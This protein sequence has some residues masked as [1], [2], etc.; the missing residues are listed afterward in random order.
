MYRKQKSLSHTS[1]PNSYWIIG[2]QQ[3]SEWESTAKR[4]I[5]SQAAAVRVRWLPP[6]P[7]NSPDLHQ[8]QEWSLARVGWTCPPQSTPWR[9]PWFADMVRCGSLRSIVVRY[10]P[11]WSNA[12]VNHRRSC[13]GTKIQIDSVMR[14]RSS[15]RG[16][17]T[18]ASVTVTLILCKLDPY[19]QK[20]SPVVGPQDAIATPKPK[21]KSDAVH[22]A[23][24]SDSWTYLAKLQVLL[25][26]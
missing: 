19:L 16:H 25:H 26:A 22:D 14:P 15:S 23:S 18:S 13:T 2:E 12:E 4:Y 21:V 6:P 3:A 9:R 24:S 5:Y 10:D 17:N 7:K 1:R 8:S 20:L 11:M